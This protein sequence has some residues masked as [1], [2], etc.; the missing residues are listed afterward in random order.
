M[1]NERLN[2]CGARHF[3]GT[4]LRSKAR[5]AS[6]REHCLLIFFFYYVKKNAWDLL[7]HPTYGARQGWLTW[8]QASLA[9]REGLL[10]LQREPFFATEWSG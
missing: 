4:P 2:P 10:H 9:G 1:K 3:V 8:G 6:G 5:A 7:S